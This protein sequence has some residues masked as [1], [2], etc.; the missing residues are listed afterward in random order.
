MSA[1]DIGTKAGVQDASKR[2]TEL[3]K[4]KKVKP[5]GKRAGMKYY[6]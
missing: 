4:D 6:K 2:L 3:K 1:A 5:D